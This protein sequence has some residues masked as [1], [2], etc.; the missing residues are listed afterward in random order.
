ELIQHCC[1]KFPSKSLLNDELVS[2]KLAAYLHSQKFQINPIMV[3]NYVKQQIISQLGIESVFTLMVTNDQMWL[4]IAKSSFR[5]LVNMNSLCSNVTYDESTFH[6][7]DGP[8]AM[9]GPEKEQP[10]RK[11]GMGLGIH[12]SDFLTKM[13]GPLRDDLEEAHAIIVLGSRYDGYWD[14]KKLI[15]KLDEQ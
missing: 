13:I 3:K 9:W 5:K 11:K 4:P 12:V 8:H 10:L 14:A 1:G 7:N 6:I 15:F 2:L